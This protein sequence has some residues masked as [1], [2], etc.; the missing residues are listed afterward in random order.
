MALLLIP[1]AASAA[2][3][4]VELQ[5]LPEDTL[6]I[7]VQDE[8][9][10]DAVVPGTSTQ[11]Q[12]FWMGITNTTSGGWD[13]DVTG[14]DL[15]AYNMECDEFGENCVRVATGPTID[16]SAI[17][18]RGGDQDNW[19]DAGAITAH[20]GNLTAAG[21]PFDLMEGTSVA[22][23]S[24]GLDEQPPAVRV[25]V[26]AGVTDYASYYTTLTYTITGS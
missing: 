12:E 2:D 5:V 19:G 24:F 21:T 22:S 4:T 25:D 20:E 23:G 26:P 8:M 10:L 14:T 9:A 1:V 6:S 18:V 16:A 7:D 11:L 13:V 15:L 17:F 3:Q